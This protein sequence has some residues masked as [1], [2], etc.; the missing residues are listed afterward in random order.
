MNKFEKAMLTTAT[1]GIVVGTVIAVIDCV[2][3]YFKVNT[4]VNFD[5]EDWLEDYDDDG[6]LI[7]TEDDEW[8]IK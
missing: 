1:T 7:Y 6:N 5:D 4:Y 8:D 2:K 3:K